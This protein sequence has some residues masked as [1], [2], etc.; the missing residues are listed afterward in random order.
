MAGFDVHFID[1]NPLN[2]D[3]GNL[4]PI[5]H[6]SRPALQA[7]LLRLET[8]IEIDRRIP[9]VV[10]GQGHRP[11]SISVVS[12]GDVARATGLTPSGI[13]S[14]ASRGV[15]TMDDPA[16]MFAFVLNHQH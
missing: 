10:N 7:G 6:V 1:G 11:R 15:F 9:D 2:C 14:A 16:S 3:K 4:V 13:R 12:Y 5:S 8:A